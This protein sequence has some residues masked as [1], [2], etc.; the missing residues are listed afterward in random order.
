V[1][2]DGAGVLARVERG[3]LVESVH[4]GHAIALAA[5]GSARVRVGDPDVAFLPRSS[6]KPLQAVAMLRAGLD[7]DGAALALAC[8]SHTGE[9]GHVDGVRAIL[10]AAGCTPA[11]LQTPPA[12][13]DNP[14]A[15]FAWRTAGY[16]P[17]PIA[18]MCSGKHA[19]MLATCATRGWPPAS[20]RD[21]AHPLQ[22]AI[23]ATVAELT[24][25]D[26]LPVVVDGCGAPAFSSTVTGIARAYA[27][28]AAAPAGTAEHRVASA[29][30]EQPWFVGGTATVATVLMLAVPG[31]L[32][33]NGA[34]G[35][36]TAATAD[37]RA[38][39][40]KILDGS[41]RAIPALVAALLRAVGVESPAPEPGLGGGDVIPAFC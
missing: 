37:G 12:V 41:P 29:M 3:G 30:R 15:A 40:V 38:L 25:D 35:G 10:D 20:Y 14:D 18:H 24:G 8:A 32:A 26:P 21:P 9:P 6:L 31:L 17:E 22:Q 11:D 33:K 23:R 34:E 5:D 2:D 13:P 39:A 27:R 16:G 1:I 36:F 4:A 7:I 28:I 19:A